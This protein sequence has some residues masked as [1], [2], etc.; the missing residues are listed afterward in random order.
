M[1]SHMKGT[2]LI[3][4][5]VC[6][7]AVGTADVF[8][9][10]WSSGTYKNTS[11]PGQVAYGLTIELVGQWNVTGCYSD[12]FSGWGAPYFPATNSQFVYYFGG[13]VNPGDQVWVGFKLLEQ[14]G[15]TVQSVGW[16]DEYEHFFVGIEPVPVLTMDVRLIDFGT[17]VDGTNMWRR[18][19]GAG[20]PPEPGDGPGE[21]LGPITVSDAYYAVTNVERP[22]ESLNDGL[23][24]DPAVTWVPLD[25]C[26]LNYGETKTFELPPLATPKVLL[27]RCDAE[28]GGEVSREY[29]QFRLP[30]VPTVSEWGLIIL[31]LLLLTVGTIL[32]ARRRRPVAA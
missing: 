11:T 17:L 20:F 14:K 27:F 10:W 18:W 5:A 1:A 21:P 22:L 25:G 29:V 6:V 31:T 4:V 3:G 30:G 9:G 26:T 12:K 16:V 7:L 28:A 15:P 24:A 32:V 8:A 23:L 2:V 19:L 13:Q